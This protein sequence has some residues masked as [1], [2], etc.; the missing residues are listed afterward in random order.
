[1]VFLTKITNLKLQI[2]SKSQIQN[3][4]IFEFRIFDLFDI[5]CLL[6]GIFIWHT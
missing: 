4:Y 1:M 2:I 3:Y 6:F 5:W